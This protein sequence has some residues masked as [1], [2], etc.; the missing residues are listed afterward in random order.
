MSQVL[1]VL[2][3]FLP[4]IAIIFLANLAERD[5]LRR[6]PGHS[7]MALLAYLMLVLIY[8]FIALVGLV[9]QGVGLMARNPAA[10]AQ[11]LELYQQLGLQAEEMEA[12]LS[13]LPTMGMALW[14]PAL[15]GLLLL[16][17]GVRRGVARVLPLDPESPVHAVALAFTMLVVMNLAFTLGIGLDTLSRAL[18]AEDTG[19]EMILVLWAQQATM[20]FWGLVGVGWP[21]RRSLGQALERLGV[22]PVTWRQAGLGVGLGLV[23]VVGVAGL[24]AAASA[25]GL[26][27]SPDVESL[28]EVLL[29]PL[30]TSVPGILTLGLSA[31]LGE[32]TVFRGALQPRFGL[33]FTSGLF[34][35]THSNYGITLSTG[36]V[37]LVGMVFGWL[38]QRH[39]TSTAM[40]AHAVYNMTLGSFVYI[41]SLV[42]GG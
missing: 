40:I 35:L 2:V 36:L 9:L 37:F 7:P 11:L 8:G 20:A 6:G 21:I 28:T 24:E 22:V 42:Q 16:L 34:A 27:P 39:N 33:V 23:S 32:E 30:L 10:Q 1:S 18:A 17:P 15:V 13:S 3:T 29:G 31:A 19:Q 5:R 12:F 41:Y 25:A 14:I 38:R 26:A 4:F